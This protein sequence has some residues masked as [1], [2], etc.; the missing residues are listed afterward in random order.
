MLL[1]SLLDRFPL[2][3]KMALRWPLLA[4]TASRQSSLVTNTPT[5]T[6][7]QLPRLLAQ[8]TGPCSQAPAH[9]GVA[10]SFAHCAPAPRA[11]VPPW[12][13]PDSCLPQVFALDVPPEM[14]FLIL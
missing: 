4:R 10:V 8:A 9:K 7:S 3:A 1:T 5:H 13:A 14:F 6:S 12:S 11:P 2:M